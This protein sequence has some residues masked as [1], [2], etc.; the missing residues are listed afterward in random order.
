[1]KTALATTYHDPAGKL[2]RQ[3]ERVLP[4]LTEVF[5]RVAVRASPT[6]NEEALASLTSA[7]A[8]LWAHR[9]GLAH[10]HVVAMLPYAATSATRVDEVS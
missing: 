6:A 7:D 3:I 10:R 2:T 4:V 1:M 9:L 8:R 5:G